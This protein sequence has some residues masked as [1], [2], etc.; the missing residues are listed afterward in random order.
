[1]FASEN[2]Q[3]G[4]GAK[5]GWSIRIIGSTTK[6]DPGKWLSD[7]LVQKIDE[8]GKQPGRGFYFD[9][10][11]LH[12]AMVKPD[13]T[14][15]QTGIDVPAPIGGRQGGRGPGRMGDDRFGPGGFVPPTGEGFGGA[16]GDR[17]TLQNELQEYAVKPGTDPLTGESTTTDWQFE[18][19]L[20]ALMGDTPKEKIPAAWQPKDPKA[21]EAAKGQTGSTPKPATPRG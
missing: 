9:G 4:P 11:V 18:I 13:R 19:R 20:L 7:V 21:D 3:A 6:S 1:V 2:E 10:V 5:P 12:Q 16:T 14:G 8:L 17:R 15:R